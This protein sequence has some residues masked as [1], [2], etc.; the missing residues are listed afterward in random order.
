MATVILVVVVTAC[1]ATY[2]WLGRRWPEA[3]ALQQRIRDER[4]ATRAALRQTTFGSRGRPW[5]LP[6]GQSWD[7]GREE[8]RR[9]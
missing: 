5:F 6:Q 3:K 4:K 1:L 7:A 8:D 2:W 9:R